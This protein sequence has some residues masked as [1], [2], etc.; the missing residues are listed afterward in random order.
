MRRNLAIVVAAVLAL[1]A[2]VAVAT[3]IAARAEEAQAS[4]EPASKEEVKALA[5]E[6]RRLKLEM[7]LG[8]VGYASYA[9]LGPAASKV[10]F[11]P[12]G[13]SLGGYAETF[14]RNELEDFGGADPADDSDLYR[15]VVYLGY[16]FSPRIVF[17]AEVEYEHQNEI[18]VEFAYLDFRLGDAVGIRAGNVL[19]PVGF[20]NEMHEP[21]FFH[22]V[23]RPEVEQRLIPTTW[24]E[25]GVGLYGD[26]A[27]LRYKAYLLVGLNAAN[28]KVA[29]D[30]WLRGARTAGGRS[31]AEDLAGVLN[32]AADVGPV[33][34]GGTVYAGRAGQGKEV[35]GQ[36][37]DADVFLGEA[38]ARMLWRG[39][40]ARAIYAVG[41]LG[42]AALVSQAAAIAD[43]TR[44]VGSRVRGGYAELAYDVL[45]RLRPEGGQALSPFVRFESY[46][47]H[48]EVPEGGV[49]NPAYD[50]DVWTAGLTYKPIPNVALKADWQRR[51]AASGAVGETIN[52]G[53][54]LV[55]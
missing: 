39:L 8:E 32:V 19:V 34:L 22:G 14:Y 13:L 30:T 38:H 7:G 28:G 44:V 51:A 5:E 11:A 37:V 9:G 4:A 27:G 29:A 23:F 26:V 31:P 12:K 43:P 16:R 18:H 15:V 24:N 3:P 45:G 49:R 41:T 53:L 10:Y 25:N 47:L 35:G 46:D 1:L 17:N 36:E 52:L 33:T 2:I 40:E 55:F 20:V 21:A 48:D 6:V 50:V 42:D 54:G